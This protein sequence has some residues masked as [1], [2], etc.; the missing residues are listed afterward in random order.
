MIDGAIAELDLVTQANAATS[1]RVATTA[2]QLQAQAQELVEIAGVLK[3][4]VHRT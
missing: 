3:V 4:L 1:E 2:H